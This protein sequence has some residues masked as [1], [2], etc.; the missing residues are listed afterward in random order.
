MNCPYCLHHT[1]SVG[2]SRPIEGGAAIRRRRRCRN[3][4]SRFTTLERVI[5]R[6]LQVIKRNG[7]REPFDWTKLQRSLMMALRKRDV[8]DDQITA[9]VNA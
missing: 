1:T 2:D 9:M 8:T 7:K 6:P 4:D 5:L 3:C